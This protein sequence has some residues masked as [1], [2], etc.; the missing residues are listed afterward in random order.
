MSFAR[1]VVLAAAVLAPV[2]HADVI[3]EDFGNGNLSNY[4]CVGC[5]DT[6]ASVAAQYAYNG[7][8][9]GLGL[10]GSAWYYRDDAP[11]QLSQ[12]DSFYVWVNT[13][14]ADDGRDYFGF[15]ASSSGALSAVLAPNTDQFIIQDNS[16]YGFTDIADVTQTYT[17]DTWYEIVVDWGVGGNITADLYA[18]DGTTLL[19]TASAVDNSIVSGGLAFRAFGSSGASSFDTVTLVT[20][21]PEPS[22]ILEL[23]S[24]LGMIVMIARR[25]FTV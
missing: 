7:A 17:A 19:N 11:V 4:T 6:T 13:G 5:P 2:C 22:S 12:G 1:F 3:I 23:C 24:G 10:N 20:T 25:R 9:Y 21:V 16:N 14:P 18:S 8:T 15:G